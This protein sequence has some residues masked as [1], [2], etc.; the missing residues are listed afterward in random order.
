MTDVLLIIPHF[1]YKKLDA[2]APICPRIGVISIAAVLEKEGFSV[3]VIDL[4]ALNLSWAELK[5]EIVN[6]SASIVGLTAVTAEFPSALQILK[7]VKEINVS[8]VTIV[9]GP[10]VSIMPET[11]NTESIDYIVAGEG[12]ITAVELVKYILQKK[13]K[14]EEIKG[15]GYKKD[16]NIILTT[17]RPL[18]ENLDSLPF[19]AY[20]LLQIDK[21][22]NYATLDDG[23]KFATIVSSRGCPFKCIFCS[24]SAVFGHRWRT[25]SP[26]RI[27]SDIKILYEKFN[28]RHLYF[29]DDEFTISKERIIK[30]CKLL[31]E[32]K[33][34]L[35]WS[36]LG[37][38]NDIDEEFAKNISEAGCSAISLGI[39]TGYPEGLKQIKKNINLEQ[40]TNAF[41]LCRKYKIFTSA[42]FMIGFPW[43]NKKEILK[44][45]KFARTLVPYA[46]IFYF[47][48]LIPY[49][50]TEVYKV[51]KDENLIISNDWNDYVTHSVTGT[52]PV[53]RTRYLTNKELKSLYYYAFLWTYM[54]P[55]YLFRKIWR[56]K[57]IIHL[58]RNMVAGYNLFRNIIDNYIN[59]IFR[60]SK[61]H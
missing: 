51:M 24:S 45:I 5:E 26:E 50:G 36:C 28:I 2:S 6:T 22:R 14:L 1:K 47:Q 34:D 15:I 57:N 39:E 23:R 48:T 3:K 31:I 56:M 4:P 58:K 59:V 49:P 61:N 11:A 54:N 52:L 19:P 7:L 35:K 17:P 42:N 60:K 21:Y 37:R 16:G 18:I 43:E 41:K 30:L 46:D 55:G 12:E 38:V 40:V 32:S 27:F 20:H 25:M 8:T 10:H 33:F 44:T 9:G 13:G 53:I 29:H